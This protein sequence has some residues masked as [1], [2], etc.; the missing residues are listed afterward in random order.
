VRRAGFGSGSGNY[1]RIGVC[2]HGSVIELRFTFLLLVCVLLRPRSRPFAGC[3]VS[4]IA[5]FTG[6]QRHPREGVSRKVKKKVFGKVGRVAPQAPGNRQPC[7]ITFETL[8]SAGRLGRDDSLSRFISARG[9]T[10]PTWLACAGRV[11]ISSN[12]DVRLSKQRR[13]GSS[14]R[15]R[16]NWAKNL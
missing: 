11:E 2:I 7:L 3:R 15:R 1:L 8:E 4:Q 10:R 14:P 9:A 5:A 6:Y 13:P 16:A 12:S